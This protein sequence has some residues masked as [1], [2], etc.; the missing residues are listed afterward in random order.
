[1]QRLVRHP[2]YS[3]SRKKNDIALVQ[4]EGAVEFT[5]IVRPA[6]IRTDP[7]DLPETR[8]LF[9]A[10]WGSI[11]ADSKNYSFISY[12]QV[13]NYLNYFRNQQIRNSTQGE[14]Y[15]CSIGTM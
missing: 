12:Q 15:K 1:M 14:C 13:S 2:Q 3:L 8:E 10:G 7:A 4:F 5:D 6:C 9:I 11:E